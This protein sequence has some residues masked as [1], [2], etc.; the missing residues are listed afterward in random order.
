MR[1]GHPLSPAPAGYSNPVLEVPE[2]VRRALMKV[3]FHVKLSFRQ[4]H[5]LLNC[6]GWKLKLLQRNILGEKM[7]L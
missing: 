4:I 3:K 5:I 6:E 1:G 7:V 2:E